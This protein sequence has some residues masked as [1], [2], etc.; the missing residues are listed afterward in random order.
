[1]VGGIIVGAL[2]ALLVSTLTNDQS[3][4]SYMIPIG[5]ACGLAV[6]AGRPRRTTD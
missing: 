3:V 4:W 6:G 2:I 1:M 5:V